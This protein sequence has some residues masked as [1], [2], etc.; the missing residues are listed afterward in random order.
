MSE[1]LNR[2]KAQSSGRGWI[3]ASVVACAL[4]YSVRFILAY[5]DQSSFWLDELLLANN[6]VDRDFAAL[7]K[8]LS[9]DQAAPP[10]FLVLAKAAT[11]LFGIYDWALRLPVYMASI[12]VFFAFWKSSKQAFGKTVALLALFLLTLNP[13]LAPYSLIFKQYIFDVLVLII[14]FHCFNRVLSQKDSARPIY[15]FAV[16]GIVATWFSHTAL[17][18]LAGLGSV[19]IVTSFLERN[20]V[21]TIRLFAIISLWVVS[22]LMQYLLILRYVKEN[23]ALHTYWEVGY[24]DWSQGW[25]GVTTWLAHIA[26]LMTDTGTLPPL[27]VGIFLILGIGFG[28]YKKSV[29][30]IGLL[31]ILGCAILFSALSLY[32]LHDR[33]SLFI[34]PIVITLVAFGIGQVLLWASSRHIVLRIAVLALVLSAAIP[35]LRSSFE[36]LADLQQLRQAIEYIEGRRAP[37]DMVYAFSDAKYAV[38]FYEQT[39]QFD[40]E[41]Y[42]L[43]EIKTTVDLGE[44][45]RSKSTAPGTKWYFWGRAYKLG[46]PNDYTVLFQNLRDEPID[47]A[48]HEYKNAYVLEVSHSLTQ[49]TLH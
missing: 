41:N 15:L 29:P 16:Y 26:S 27:I 2:S 42:S 35:P 32:P 24:L 3:L 5:L 33:L 49:K 28:F 48:L 23:D 37:E 9:N 43:T 14:G 39:P 47:L 4:L 6:L 11:E 21:L 17:F 45:I 40:L 36:N 46:R 25:A 12:G 44:M 1:D 31:A 18:V 34:V 30:V 8:P 10:F 7:F 19:A 20:R 38:S 13:Q 22:F